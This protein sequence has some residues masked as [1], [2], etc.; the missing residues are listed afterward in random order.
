MKYLLIIISFLILSL[1]YYGNIK[2]SSNIDNFTEKVPIE[3]KEKILIQNKLDK[4]NKTNNKLDE[5]TISNSNSN[6]H[7]NIIS[8]ND[9]NK[10][11]VNGYLY[12]GSILNNKLNIVLDKLSYSSNIDNTIKF[13]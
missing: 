1:L 10:K 11:I 3:I 9:S 4:Q 2:N 7:T 8:N 13:Q 6:S 5:R 12:S